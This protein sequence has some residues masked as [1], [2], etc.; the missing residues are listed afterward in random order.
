MDLGNLQLYLCIAIAFG[1]RRDLACIPRQATT[2]VATNYYHQL[3]H[4]SLL[5]I[6]TRSNRRDICGRYDDHWVYYTTELTSF[7][8]PKG[9]EVNSGDLWFLAHAGF[10]QSW[11]SILRLPS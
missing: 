6:D 11:N 10:E 2:T 9:L 7:C 1:S 3:H 8:G 4:L 5:H